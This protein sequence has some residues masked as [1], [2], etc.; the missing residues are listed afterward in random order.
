MEREIHQN[1]MDYVQNGGGGGNDETE[2]QNSSLS[3]VDDADDGRDAV[4]PEMNPEEYWRPDTDDE[5]DGANGG[6]AN[7]WDQLVRRAYYQ[8]PTI[9]VSLVSSS[10]C[11]LYRNPSSGSSNASTDDQDEIEMDSDFIMDP[12]ISSSTDD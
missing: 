11:E 9:Q 6:P 12:T 1:Y 3:N 7:D 5:D 10:V 2:S 8:Q 4:M